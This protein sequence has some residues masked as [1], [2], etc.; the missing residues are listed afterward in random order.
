MAFFHEA[1]HPTYTGGERLRIVDGAVVDESQVISPIC[2]KRVGNESV[3][4]GDETL[5]FE[6]RDTAIEGREFPG[7]VV[8]ADVNQPARD[9]M[10]PRALV[11]VVDR[12]D[13][14]HYGPQTLD[15]ADEP[16]EGVGI[17]L[18]IILNEDHGQ[19]RTP[20]FW[21]SGRHSLFI[22]PRGL[23]GIQT[24]RQDRPGDKMTGEC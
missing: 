3:D 12:H 4:I 14:R 19:A 23:L 8:A 22:L 13:R 15:Q 18:A 7:G 20:G 16:L 10:H 24:D 11:T 6:E 1:V 2:Q 5:A 21:R 9:A 17:F